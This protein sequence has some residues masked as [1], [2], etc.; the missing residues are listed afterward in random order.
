M[1]RIILAALMLVV[2]YGL[3]GTV[4][5]QAYNCGDTWRS[6]RPDTL[7]RAKLEGSKHAQVGRWAW[8]AFLLK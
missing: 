8:D 4:S 5:V 6:D 1:K 2:S 3:L 7:Y